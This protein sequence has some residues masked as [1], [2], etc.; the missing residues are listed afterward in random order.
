MTKTVLK[1]EISLKNRAIKLKKYVHKL[2]KD[3]ENTYLPQWYK[4]VL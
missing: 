3:N 4:L 2:L 1:I